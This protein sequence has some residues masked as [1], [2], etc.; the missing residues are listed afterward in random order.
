MTRILVV[1][2]DHRVGAVLEQGLR[3]EGY[4]VDRALDGDQAIARGSGADYQLVLLDFMLPGASGPDVARALRQAGRQM[5]ILMLTARD[6]PEELRHAR[7]CG[8]NAV[9]GKPF[10]FAEL[11]D[12]VQALL[13]GAEGGS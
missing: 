6:A 8:V 7:E 10:R 5:P 13:D 9:M 12:R 1:E 3:E 2:D 4:L 11:M